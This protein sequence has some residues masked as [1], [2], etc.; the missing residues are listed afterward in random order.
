[1]PFRLLRTLLLLP[2]L[3]IAKGV[4]ATTPL[5]EAEVA[6]QRTFPL[7][8]FG[9]ALYWTVSETVDWSLTLVQGETSGYTNYRV[10][11]FDWHPGFRAG[12][13]YH[14]PETRW[15]TQCYYTHYSAKTSAHTK[16]HD[17]LIDPAFL[18]NRTASPLI[19]TYNYS[20]ASAQWRLRFDMA[21]WD[22]RYHF[23]PSSPLTLRPYL[24]IKGGTIKQSI[25]SH[26][27]NPHL[28]LLGGLLSATENLRNDFWGVGPKGGIH[29]QWIFGH[30][31]RWAFSLFGDFSAAYMWGRWTIKDTYRNN[32]HQK[33]TTT[34]GNRKYGSFMV[35]AFM[36]LGIDRKTCRADSLL[37]LKIGYELQDWFSQFQIF[38]NGTGGHTNDLI[39]QGLTAEA[40]FTF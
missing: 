34:V 8:V 7:S 5:E 31:S 14:R 9:D 1:M 39:L 11:S 25:H 3:F 13:S 18:G 30:P 36:G 17:G 22:F 4:V 40:R 35:R 15:D 6:P 29:T 21:D 16:T 24:G 33:A 20:K 28:F 27:L 26:W 19:F 10:L 12:L 23:R 37:S 32:L 38:D 2:L